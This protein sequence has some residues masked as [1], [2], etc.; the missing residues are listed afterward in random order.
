VREAAAGAGY[1]R[2]QLGFIHQP[3]V[4]AIHGDLRSIQLLEHA[5]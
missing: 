5:I 4:P 1:A 3:P 2:D